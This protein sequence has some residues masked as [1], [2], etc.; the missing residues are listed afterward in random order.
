MAPNDRSRNWTFTLNNPTE[1]QVP[2]T[3]RSKH[4]R[5]IAF[6]REI[7]PGTGTPH[8][9]GFVCYTNLKSFK[10]VKKDFPSCHL[11]IMKGSIAQNVEYI[12][13]ENRPTVIGDLPM[14]QAQKGAANKKIFDDAWEAAKANDMD[15]IPAHLRLRFYGTLKRIAK[16]FMVRPDPLDELSNEWIHGPTGTG[17]SRHTR[18]R[19]PDA[20][21]KMANK[22]WD[23]Y[24]GEDV[25]VIED[26]D[27]IHDKLGYHLKI[28]ADY[29][30]FLAETKGGVLTIRPKKFVITSNYTI[31]EIWN[32]ENTAA[33]LERRF[34]QVYYGEEKKAELQ[35]KWTAEKAAKEALEAADAAEALAELDKTPANSP[36]IIDLVENYSPM[37]LPPIPDNISPIKGYEGDLD[38]L[39]LDDIKLNLWPDSSFCNEEVE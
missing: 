24:Q 17:K 10:L 2:T 21:Y 1:E 6:A 29:G 15:A 28:W 25:V 27:A 12:S 34:A 8:L 14:T 38:T 9:Q 30:A 35:L 26:F 20:Y 32:E 39:S 23:G 16:D 4:M 37:T 13:K 22:W 36:K 3:L 5:C 19:F 31:R 33:P 18:E 11:E 7:A